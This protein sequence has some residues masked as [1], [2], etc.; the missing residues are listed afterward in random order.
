M[1]QGE[2]SFEIENLKLK[3]VVGE[4]ISFTE[5]QIEEL[6]KKQEIKK[7]EIYKPSKF[8]KISARVLEQLC[9]NTTTKLSSEG[10]IDITL[11]DKT[12]VARWKKKYPEIRYI[13]IS[14]I[15]IEITALFRQGIDTPVLAVVLD[16][17][18]NDPLKAI[19]GGIQ[20]NLVNGVVWF[21]IR[22]NFFIS[23][24]DPNLEDTV[25]KIRI[26][27]RG[28]DM[29]E[30]SHDLSIRWKTIHKLTRL[31]QTSTKYSD[32]NFVEIFEPRPFDIEISPRLIDWKDLEV[33]R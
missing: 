13:H 27:T 18:F 28:I 24:N 33:P 29:K 14:H 5:E 12:K 22:P 30:S 19:I 6:K 26:K 1:M 32:K 23:I 2:E 16:K 3:D 8:K 25:V 15:Q 10:N 11:F 21:N 9:G 31:P 4:E 17:R 20:S 7:E